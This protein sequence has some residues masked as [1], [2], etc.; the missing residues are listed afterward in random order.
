VVLLGVQNKQYALPEASVLFDEF[1]AS[2]GNCFDTAYIYGGG[3]C[4]QILGQWI[5]NRGIREQVVILDKGAHT[6]NCYPEAL[7]SQLLETL[8]RMQ[9]DY[10]DLYVMHRDNEEVPVGEFIDVLNEHKNAGRIR[11]FGGSNWTL[12]RIEAANEY[13]RRKGL[14]GMAAVSNNL[15]LARMVEPVWGGCITAHDPESRVWFTQTQMPLLAW[16]SLARGFFVTGDPGNLS[17]QSMVTSW[18]SD[19]NFQ[20]LDRAR[21]LAKKK[22]VEPV[23]IALAWVLCQPFPTFALIGPE[24]I[25]Q[26]RI[27]LKALGVELTPDELKWLNLETE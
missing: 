5:A 7:T 19:D 20:R 24:N 17:N 3:F 6:P 9:T 12:A 26:L 4:E 16:S 21:E 1:F 11:A 10:T 23:A 22:G 27:S 18:Y 15:S 8:D 2:G 13:A 14:T 25:G